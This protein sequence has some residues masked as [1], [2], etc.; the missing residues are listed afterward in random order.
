MPEVIVTLQVLVTVNVPEELAAKVTRE[1]LIEMARSACPDSM[2]R[3][4]PP[5]ATQV[6]I[7]GVAQTGKDERPV[8]A[9]L[10]VEHDITSEPDFEFQDDA[11]DRA[12]EE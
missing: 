7:N 3:P 11:F 2:T 8:F 9:E 4:G 5:E 12:I 6:V 1:D 10:F